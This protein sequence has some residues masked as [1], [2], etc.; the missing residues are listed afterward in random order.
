MNGEQILKKGKKIP[1]WILMGYIICIIA[2]IGSSFIMDYKK[3]NKMPEAIDFSTSRSVKM[4]ENKYVYLEIQGLTKEVAVYGNVENKNDSTNDRYYIA[5]NGAYGYIVDLNFDTIDTLKALQE[6]TYSTDENTIAP[7]NVKIYGMTEN[8]PTELKQMVVDFYN[9]GVEEEYQINLEDFEAYF[10]SVLLN[11]RKNP[12]DTYVEKM[13]I[14]LATI[15]IFVIT[16]SHIIIF[17]VKSRTKKYIKKNGYEG[18]LVRQ[19]YD[20]VEEKHY[21]DKVILTKDFL[22]DI[23]GTGFTVFKYADVKWVHIH[24]VKYYGTITVSSSI[25]LHLNDGKTQMQCVEIRGDSTEEFLGIFNK[26]CEKVPA[27]CLKGFTKENQQEF[28]Q[29]KKDLKRKIL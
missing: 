7:K 2:I 27:D 18:E 20:C 10:G 16:I 28:K 5:F 14:M 12:V 24:N 11:V 21:K 25:I 9:E 17:I 6:Y 8:I 29:Y 23:K 26:I 15:G 4:P 19:L 1:M 13:V 3:K 22:V